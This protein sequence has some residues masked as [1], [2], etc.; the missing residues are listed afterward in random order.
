LADVVTRA[1]GLDG[2]VVRPDDSG[3]WLAGLP[4][5]EQTA[6]SSPVEDDD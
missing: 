3:V 1:A 2:L 4:G 6:N 5:A